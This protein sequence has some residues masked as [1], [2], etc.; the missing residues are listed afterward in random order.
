M[1][2]NL[3]AN[4]KSSRVRVTSKVLRVWFSIEI[5]ELVAVDRFVDI[6]QGRAQQSV[7]VKH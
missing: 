4:S 1:E 7:L 3:E 2:E 6:F 5:G